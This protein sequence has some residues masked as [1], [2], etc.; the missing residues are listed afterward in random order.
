MTKCVRQAS[1]TGAM[2]SSSEIS[3]N[4]TLCKTLML[5]ALKEMSM[6]CD[7][8]SRSGPSISL[9]GPFV[10]SDGSWRRDPYGQGCSWDHGV[11]RWLCNGTR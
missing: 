2:K 3:T 5:M 11:G 7:D 6:R 1:V 8:F 4:G 9:T 10:W